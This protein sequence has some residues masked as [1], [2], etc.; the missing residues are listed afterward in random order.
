MIAP[1]REPVQLVYCLRSVL[2]YLGNT[3]VTVDL[4]RGE[5]IA[6]L[7]ILRVLVGEY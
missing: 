4:T 7:I 2:Q 3:R 1:A 6:A 5:Q